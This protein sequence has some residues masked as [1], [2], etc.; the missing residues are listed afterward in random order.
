[1]A[2]RKML[3]AVVEHSGVTTAFRAS[4]LPAM[5]LKACRARENTVRAGRRDTVPRCA[6]SQSVPS[7]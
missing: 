5:Q 3:M 7:S 1:M 4:I 2:D 6:P